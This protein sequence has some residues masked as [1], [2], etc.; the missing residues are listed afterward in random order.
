MGLVY[1]RPALAS[2]VHFEHG[3]PGYLTL[4]LLLFV[5]YVCG[6][7]LFYGSS[8]LSH[9][10]AGAILSRQPITLISEVFSKNTSWRKAARKFLG[11]ELTPETLET[12]NPQVFEME[13]KAAQ[14]IPDEALRLVE[15]QRVHQEHNPRKVSDFAWQNWYDAMLYYF[16][17]KR[18]HWDWEPMSAMTIF[19]A[20][21]WAG[22][23][24]F[25]VVPAFR[26]PLFIIVSLFTTLC[27]LLYPWGVQVSMLK[28]EPTQ[29]QV[30]ASLITE[31][32]KD[33]SKKIQQPRQ[34]STQRRNKSPRVEHA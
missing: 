28:N 33:E 8:S 17:P 22:I 20:I 14:A 16:Y 26:H 5:A 9:M 10:F 19:H 11:P 18:F 13:L 32:R 3:L 12:F 15:T 29:V 31:F 1:G 27:G 6:F 4:A 25:L 30:M 2:M 7:V 23:F 21:G 24:L 34:P